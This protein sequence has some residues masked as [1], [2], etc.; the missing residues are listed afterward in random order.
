MHTSSQGFRFLIASWIWK[1][2]MKGLVMVDYF[3]NWL[4]RVFQLCYVVEVL[5]LH[6]RLAAE[7]GTASSDTFFMSNAIIEGL[8]ISF[9]FLMRILKSLLIYLLSWNW[10]AMFWGNPANNVSYAVNTRTVNTSFWPICLYVL[11]FSSLIFYLSWRF[12]F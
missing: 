8:V 9:T 3:L 6:Q 11:E 7:W 10:G 1:V 2:R 5:V 4:I 12:F